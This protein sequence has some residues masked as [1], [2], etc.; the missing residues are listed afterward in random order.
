MWPNKLSLDCALFLAWKHRPAALML[1]Q[2]IFV[3]A[4]SKSMHNLAHPQ[5]GM[6]HDEG[7]SDGSPVANDWVVVHLAREPG[8]VDTAKQYFTRGEYASA[9]V[10]VEPDGKLRR[11]QEPAPDHAEEGRRDV[12][13]GQRWKGQALHACSLI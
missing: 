10:P 1:T 9:D 6:R 13:L 12:L 2:C 3:S 5:H 4:F 11:V 7:S 8:R